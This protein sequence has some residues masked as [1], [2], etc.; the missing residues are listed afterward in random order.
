MSS[1]QVQL[2][3][4]TWSVPPIPASNADTPMTRKHVLQVMRNEKLR[5]PDLAPYFCH[6]PSR[7]H[8][9]LEKLRVNVEDWLDRFASETH[10]SGIIANHSNE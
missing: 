3:L 2:A 7:T 6:W 8:P 5:I 4:S 9:E 10:Y 1:P